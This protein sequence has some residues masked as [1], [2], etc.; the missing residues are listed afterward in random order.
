MKAINFLKLIIALTGIILFTFVLKSC[1]KSNDVL[2][3][4]DPATIIADVKKAIQQKYG[5][6]SAGFVY[7]VNKTA[8]AIFYKNATG[9]MVKLYDYSSSLLNRP[10]VN[11]SQTSNPADLTIIY[12]LD[13]VQRFY[14]CENSTQS[15]I[16]A[17]WT[18]SVPFSI[19]A[20]PNSY[21]KVKLTP[22][23]GPAVE[24]NTQ[25]GTSNF[26]V[27]YLGPACFNNKLY[28]ITYKF[29]GVSNSDLLSGTTL[30]AFIS[31]ENDYSLLG[32]T[33]SSGYVSAPSFSQDPYLP[34]NRI[35]KMYVNPNTGPSNCATAAGNYILCSP[36]SGLN[37]IDYHQVEYRAVNHSTSFLWDDQTSSVYW[38]Q[39]TGTGTGD[40]A[41]NPSTGVSN[42]VQMTP[43]SGTW[44]VRYRNVKTSV[45]DIINPL[46]G[47]PRVVHGQILPFGLPKYG[48]YNLLAV[49][50]TDLRPVALT[51]I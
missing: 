41:L 3:D 45:C 17:K 33:A 30:D 13:Y 21:G 1:K 22:T 34:C 16:T 36:P 15:D 32:Y 5:D 39:P 26:I 11:C 23:S 10:C 44:L 14:M 50:A 25:N 12:T 48:F 51:F 38:G 8:A 43:S 2:P 29:T 40:P 46:P 7:P 42:L 19:V 4:K 28:E 6:I 18:V 24:L 20:T 35:D 9:N 37:V 27:T 47:V 49:R 31:L